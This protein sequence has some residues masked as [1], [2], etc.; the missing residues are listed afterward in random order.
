MSA[1]DRIRTAQNNRELG[2]AARSRADAAGHRRASVRW[3]DEG[4]DRSIARHNQAERDAQVAREAANAAKAKA[5]TAI[6][7]AQAVE[8]KLQTALDVMIAP[9]NA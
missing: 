8:Q 4:A 5:E 3:T 2:R 6:G 9:K 1:E 7:K